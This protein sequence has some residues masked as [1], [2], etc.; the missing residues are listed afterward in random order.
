MLGAI[1]APNGPGS[2]TI[3]RNLRQRKIVTL[4]ALQ[5]ASLN[6]K[7]LGLYIWHVAVVYL[8]G[9]TETGSVA[10]SAIVDLLMALHRDRVREGQP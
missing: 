2:S 3:R 6:Y 9:T 5:P 8:I 1:S 4:R 10:W 7:V